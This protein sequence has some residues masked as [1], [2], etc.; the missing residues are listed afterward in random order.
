M[1]NNLVFIEMKKAFVLFASF[2]LL[3][4]CSKEFIES[5]VLD[6]EDGPTSLSVLGAMHYDADTR[7]IYTDDGEGGALTSF[8]IGETDG[9]EI[10]LYVVVKATDKALTNVEM[11]ATSSV[12]KNG[13]EWASFTNPLLSGIVQVGDEVYSYYPY[14]SSELEV[15]GATTRSTGTNWDGKRGMVIA[16]EQKMKSGTV[17]SPSFEH[18][19]DYFPLVGKPTTVT[20]DDDHKV[21][22]LSFS[23]PFALAKLAIRNRTSKELTVTGFDWSIP[24]TPLTG[25]YSVDLTNPNAVPQPGETTSDKVSVVFTDQPTVSIGDDV[26]GIAILAPCTQSKISLTVHTTTGDYFREFSPK[27]ATDYVHEKINGFTVKID[28]SNF[29]QT[30]DWKKV[31]EQSELTTG[32]YVMVYPQGTEYK[33]FSF[34]KTM[35]NAQDAFALLADK[36]S[37]EEVLP[38]RTELFQ[39]CINGNYQTVTSPVENAELLDIPEDIANEVAMEATTADGEDSNGSVLLKSSVKNLNFTTAIISLDE[40]NAATI[41]AQ[42]NAVDVKDI[43]ANLRGHEISV[44]FANVLTFAGNKVGVSSS[45]MSSALN[46][47][48]KLCVV[49]KDVLQEH[50]FGTLMDIDRN[51]RVLDVFARYYDNVAPLSLAYNDEVAFGWIKPVGFYAANDGFSAHIPMPAS[52]W[53]DRLDASL[54]YN[55]GGKAGF[56][57]YWKKFDQDYPKYAEFLGRTTLFGRLAEKLV[58]G[59]YV[60]DELFDEVANINW[61]ELGKTYQRYADSLNGDPLEKVYLYKY[62]GE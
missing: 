7:T 31:T 12:L 11:K 10:G 53:F 58:E 51:T 49:A 62:V 56:V 9:D 48:D 35:A 40:D 2:V 17:D 37:F 16:S 32:K 19:G 18:V 22:E 57:A 29:V 13:K 20:G 36:H 27:S 52:I 42:V 3:L 38:M 4:S 47:F 34:E 54:S 24:G 60:S 46:V 61:T 14:K 33:V 26:C 59:D 55:G 44:T 6:Q 21:I 43:L 8:K 23:N 41:T 25:S 39:T 28:D 45:T 15:I 50:N 5:P 30:G 1:R